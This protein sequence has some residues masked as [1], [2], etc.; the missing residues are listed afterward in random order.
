MRIATKAAAALALLATPLPALATQPGDTILIASDSTAAN[1]KKG[2]YPQTGWGMMLGCGLSPRGAGVQPC[3]GRPIDPYLHR[4]RAL[5]EID[6]RVDARRHGADP[7][8]P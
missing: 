2:N 6:E 4:G 7:V 5:D 8:R 3:D 1:Y